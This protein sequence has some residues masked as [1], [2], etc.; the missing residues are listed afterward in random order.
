MSKFRHAVKP[1]PDP[2][3]VAQF[4]AGADSR[5]TVLVPVSEAVDVE[6][7]KRITLRLDKPRWR[8]LRAHCYEHE[9]SVQQFLVDALDAALAAVQHDSSTA[10]QHDSMTN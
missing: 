6:D 5:S 1:A 7:I 4:A 10:R 9:V 3:A 2:K 8:R